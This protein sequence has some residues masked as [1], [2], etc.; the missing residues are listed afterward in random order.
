MLEILWG[1]VEKVSRKQRDVQQLC[2]IGRL[3]C[4]SSM[5]TAPIPNLLRRA[6]VMRS[7]VR[8]LGHAQAEPG[9]LLHQEVLVSSLVHAL[10]H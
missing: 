5:F 6:A 3:S 9:G 4:S 7:D 1:S 2:Q 8:G 10:R